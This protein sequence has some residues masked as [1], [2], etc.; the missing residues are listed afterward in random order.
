MHILYHIIILYYIILYILLYIIIII[1]TFIINIIY[2][3][4]VIDTL[5]SLLFF[6]VFIGMNDVGGG[7]KN[8]E[9]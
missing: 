6:E 4:W 2:Y 9:R 1:A 5:W 3:Y 8:K 7:W